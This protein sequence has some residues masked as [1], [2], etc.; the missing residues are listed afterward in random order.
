M[1]TLAMNMACVEAKDC[2]PV[3]L[4]MAGVIGVGFVVP[5]FVAAFLVAVLTE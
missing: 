3:D 4:F 2:N 5:S 1:A